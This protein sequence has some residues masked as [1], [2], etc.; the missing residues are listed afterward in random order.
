MVIGSYN[1]F[2]AGCTVSTS[3]IGDYNE[4]SLKSFVE[5]NCKVGT[6]NYVGPKVV[7]SVGTKLGDNRIV[8]E[9]DKI[10]VN[11]DD[12][13]TLTKKQKIKE[14]GTLLIGT[15]MKYNQPKKA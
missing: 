9:D 7:L 4:I 15:L 1:H 6:N 12:S 11:D 10:L 3:E 14:L 13:S 2:E 5:D 8:Y